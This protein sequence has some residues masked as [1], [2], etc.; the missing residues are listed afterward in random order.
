MMFYLLSVLNEIHF[1]FT[2]SE[3]CDEF[4]FAETI[5]QLFSLA[6][7]FLF[8]DESFAIDLDAYSLTL[9]LGRCDTRRF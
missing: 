3:S 8:E 2:S 6:L 5:K 7:E 9:G 4:N 1:D